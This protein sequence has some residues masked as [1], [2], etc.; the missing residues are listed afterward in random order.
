M[1]ENRVYCGTCSA[2]TTD[3]GYGRIYPNGSYTT[4]CK[5]CWETIDGSIEEATKID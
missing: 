4:Y 1:I 3:F 2:D 5:T